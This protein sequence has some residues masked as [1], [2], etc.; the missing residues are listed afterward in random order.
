MDKKNI[1][2][3][4]L[5]L[6]VL[7][8]LVA[9]CGYSETITAPVGKNF[10]EDVKILSS[11]EFEG[12][13][14]ASPGGIKA[15]NYIE[16]RFKEIGLS[17][18]NGESY[19]QAVPL[20]ETESSEFS[21][22]TITGTN[23]ALTLNYPEEMVVGSY[24]MDDKITLS[25]SEVIFAGYGIVAPEYNWNDYENIDVK[26]KT[27]ILLVND[28]GFVTKDS[29]MFNGQAMTY[30]GR[31]T[32]KFEEATR[33]GAAAALIV[34]QTEPASY[35]WDVVRNSW[36]GKQYS[37]VVDGNT[38]RLPVEGWIHYNAAALLFREAGIDIEQA[39]TQ[40]ARPGFS[41]MPLKAEAS[42]SFRNRY[43]HSECHN[44]LGYIEG[45]RY[46][47]E[48]VIYMAHWDHL[49]QVK[50]DDRVDIYNGAIDN[51]TGVAALFSIAEAFLSEDEAPERSV[52]FMAV[53]AEESG[54]LGSKYYAGHPTFPVE[55]TVAGI[56]IDAMNVY[57]P[58]NDVVSVGYGFSELDNILEKHAASQNRIVKPDPYPERG[59]YF[60]SD[61]INLAR[62][63]VPM[64]YAKGGNDY[65]GKDE[66]YSQMVQED[67]KMRYHTPDDVVNELWDYDGI[68][69]D[70]HLY[71][72]IGKE[73]ANSSHF[74]NWDEGNEFKAVR[75]STQNLRRN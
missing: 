52:L 42:V 19:F 54:L 4:Y 65:M 46:P 43:S 58:T 64:I 9:S 27:V 15:K 72:L 16:K 28:P 21:P 36:S 17:P 11:D 5:I 38:G 35:G 44:V 32:Y 24:R 30:Y 22:L 33:H 6:P 50:T 56:N 13:A 14:P 25:N 57:G 49:G 68:N 71:F 1:F 62:K 39:F 37:V 10:E 60:R 51:A 8:A 53:T 66:E 3:T 61:H 55:T 40:A 69:Q 47:E 29:S 23:Y 59:S 26:G 70:L 2:K 74:P 63:G 20:L 41:A 73:L 45:S 31:W 67:S 48:T 12:R 34:H 18:G 75:D 7:M